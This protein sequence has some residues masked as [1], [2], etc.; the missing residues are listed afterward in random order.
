MA[1]AFITDSIV[2][3][4]AF[5]EASAGKPTL[6]RPYSLVG[7]GQALVEF[8]FFAPN[9]GS[10]APADAGACD[11]SLGGWRSHPRRLRGVSSSLAIG[12]RR[13]PALHLRRFWAPCAVLP[14]GNERPHRWDLPGAAASAPS[15]PS[16]A[17]PKARG[18][19]SLC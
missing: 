5:A 6:R 17:A 15:S 18:G 13:L 2:K 12:T 19:R 8:Q 11:R 4:P 14:D 16:R 9:E 1:R 10:G 3:Q 7:P